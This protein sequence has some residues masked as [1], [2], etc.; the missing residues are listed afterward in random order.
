M[1]NISWYAV[2]S[3]ELK[4]VPEWRRSYGIDDG[5]KVF[6]PAAMSGD[7]NELIVQLC[8]ANDGQATALHLDHH[9]VPSKWLKQEFP[10]HRELIEL[11][12]ANAA[13]A[14]AEQVELSR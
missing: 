1:S 11:L 10:K 2:P 4:R 8:A 9:Y 6:V 13:D 14:L 5:G 3:P 12:E 7:D